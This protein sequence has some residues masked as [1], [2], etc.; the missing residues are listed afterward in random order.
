MTDASRLERLE[1][2]LASG[3]DSDDRVF[4]LRKLKEAQAE[5]GQLRERAICIGAQ[6]VERL[7]NGEVV[8][9]N[10]VMLIGADSLRAPPPAPAEQI[11]G[12]RRAWAAI[13]N[14][15]RRGYRAAARE[16]RAIGSPAGA[17][18]RE[19]RV[20]EKMP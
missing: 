5:L 19:R 9:V 6:I 18:D 14:E 4:L 1:S 13:Y 7:R 11:A 8:E 10:D 15:F 16:A 3:L 2:W 20:L 12:D 17:E